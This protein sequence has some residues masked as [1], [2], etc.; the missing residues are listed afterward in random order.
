MRNYN[1]YML[2]PL[3]NKEFQ[4]II[5]KNTA[6]WLNMLDKEANIIMWNKAA[7]NISGYSKEEVLGNSDIWELLYPD[8]E[9]R[10]SIYNKALEIINYGKKIIDFETTITRKDGTNRILSWNTHNMRDEND[11]IIG[12]IA[13]ARDVTEI[14][15]NEEQLKSL[16]L[17]LKES[18]KKLL[19]L[20]Y[21]DQ[22]TNIPNRRAYEEKITNELEAA[23]RSGK[24]LSLLMIDI[25]KFKEYNDTYGHE[26]GDIV[27]FRVSNQVRNV[28][29]RKTDFLARYG[30]E[31]IVIILPYT[32]INQAILIG[33]RILECI[34]DL[35]IE[36]SYS[37]FNKKLTISIG[38]AS[39]ETGLDNVLTHADQALYKAKNNGRNRFEIYTKDSSPF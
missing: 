10:I 15:A 25:D 29:P 5:L 32:P 17:E 14:K 3:I 35:N 30:G 24:E 4:R 21:V 22:L 38:I 33:Q 13:I 36:H 2:N 23:K 37:Q 9:Y 8:E 39:T 31:E 16:A 1:K 12:S 26:N 20:S 11:N 19:E 28:L 34:K 18:N 27:L 7:E 6:M